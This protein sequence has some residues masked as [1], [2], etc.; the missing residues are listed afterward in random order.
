VK[1]GEGKTE[2]GMGAI[3]R[4]RR[5]RVEGRVG[6]A[7]KSGH[8][9]VSLTASLGRESIGGRIKPGRDTTPCHTPH[10][11][12]RLS[13]IMYLL[14][15]LKVYPFP[16]SRCIPIAKGCRHWNTP[17][18]ELSRQAHPTSEHGRS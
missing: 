5:R 9:S 7:G 15:P 16:A 3:G 12:S 8:G 18:H 13:C 4:G 10:T 1:E 17:A 14:A 2:E 6:G 11:A